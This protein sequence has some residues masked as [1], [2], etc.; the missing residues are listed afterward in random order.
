MTNPSS[1]PLV[2]TH[3]HL[4]LGELAHDVDGSWARARASGVVAAV[5]PAVDGASSRAVVELVAARERLFAAVGV[6]PNESAN[7]G[8]SDF[9]AIAALARAGRSNKVV[10]IGETGLDLYRDRASLDVQRASLARHA[11]LA[12]ECDLPL[13]LHVR[14]AFAPAAE[15]LEPFAR[16]GLRAVLHCFDGGAGDLRPFV[17]W[18]FFVSFS[19]L[20][21]FPKRDDLREA[22]RAAPLDRLVVETDAPFLAPVPQRG[23]PNEPAFVAHTARRLA[24][25]RGLAFEE[26][27]A[28]TTANAA[29]LFRLPS[30]AA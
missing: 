30:F 8:E 12:L 21:T 9:A 7:C 23:R 25:T 22:A 14:A 1:P 24:E 27:A 6:H 29:R 13:V 5:V 2:D 20:L 15:A 19:G 16:R 10:A 28:V 17:E 11:E 3:C 18:G 26:M 4:Y